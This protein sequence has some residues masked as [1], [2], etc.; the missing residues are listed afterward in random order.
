M[1]LYLS[2]G[3]LPIAQLSLTGQETLNNVLIYNIACK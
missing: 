1:A 3:S 2:E